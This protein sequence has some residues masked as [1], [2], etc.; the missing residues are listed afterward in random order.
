MLGLRLYLVSLTVKHFLNHVSVVV[1]F[2]K[3]FLDF[4]ARFMR[5]FYTEHSHIALEF[6]VIL[7]VGSEHFWVMKN[8]LFPNWV[9]LGILSF[10]VQ[11]RDF[12]AISLSI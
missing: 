2:L 11:R 8:V 12:S 4:K 7:L 9:G 6:H 1:K 10:Y 3:E 5:E